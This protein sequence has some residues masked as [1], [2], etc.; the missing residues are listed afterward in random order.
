MV[1]WTSFLP[2]LGSAVSVAAAATSKLPSAQVVPGAYIVEL[3]DNHDSDSFYS[4]LGSDDVAVK[5]RLKLDYKLFKGTSFQLKNVSDMDGAAAK[6]ANMDMVMRMWPVRIFNV[7]KDEVIWKGTDGR[8]E[9]AQAALKKRQSG[10]ATTDTF[11]THVMTQVNQLRQEGV[12]GSGI[13]I[14]VIDTGI[15]YLHPALGGGFGAGHLVS[16]GTDLVGDDYTGFN[17]PVPDPDPIDECEGHGSHVAGIIA[18]Q[19]NP[20]GF[21]GAAPDVTLGAYR[22]FGC[23][24]SAG[25]DVLIAAYNQAYEDGSD[26]ITASIGG[27]SGWTEDPWAVAVQRIVEAGVPCTVSAGNDGDQGLFYASTAANGK[28]V[29]A[30]ASVDNTQS[31]QVLTNA[32]YSTGNSS[33]ES[34]GWTPGSPAN[35]PNVSLPLWNVNNDPTDTANGC[36][37]YPADTPDLSGYIVL[38]RRGTCTFVQKATNAAAYGAKYVLFYNNVEGLISVSAAVDGIEGTGMV[39]AEQGEEW[40]ADLASG[41]TVTVNIV[42]PKVAPIYIVSQPNDVTG[43]FLSTYTSWGP[44]YEVDVKPQLAAPGG[45]ILSTY[46][47]AL[48]SYAVLSGTSMACP[49]AAA[50]TALVAEV[51]GT[52]DPV[53]LENVLSATSNP[54]LFNDGASTYPVLAPVAQQGSG[55]LQAYDAAYAKTVLSVSSISFNDTANLVQTTNFTIQNTGGDEVTFDLANVVAAT[56]YTLEAGTIFPSPFPNELDTTGATLS[57]SEDKVTVPAGGS[58]VVSVTVSPPALDATRLPVYSGYI[59]LNSTSDSLSLPYLGVVGS[60]KNATVLSAADTYLTTSADPNANPISGNQ[61]FTIPSNN[62]TAPNGTAY[63]EVFLGLALGSSYVKLEV[64]PQTGYN[65]SSLGNI[66]GF[67]QVY[68]P[69][70]GSVWEFNG[71]LEDGSFAPAGSYTFKV[72]ALHIFGDMAKESDY[73][74]T[75][76]ETFAIKY[77]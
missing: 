13:K 17:T 71:Q 54:N 66:F 24:G 7:P 31:P 61:T 8:T 60:M 74:V 63:P 28:G 77:I 75:E 14:A 68:L 62:G 5:H 65:T 49:L 69:R 72:S 34:F 55:L 2:L 6:I 53:E 59:T 58:A 42:D 12:T 41:I 16:Y 18:A 47:R 70:G 32:T 46:P 23:G 57:F 27:A 45:M 25:N 19:E 56:G 38:I 33:T 36:D 51:R 76:T 52:F 22:V 3:A 43:G 29:T 20:Y 1:H 4:T 30:I 64:I 44:T 26:I 11:S 40:V 9:F 48:G 15:D 73:D 10:N 35:W 39:T 67:P 37:A 21:T 50:I